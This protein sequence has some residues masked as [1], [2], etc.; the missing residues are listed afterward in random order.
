[1]NSLVILGRQPELGLAELESLYGAKNITSFGD[2]F[3]LVDIPA[4]KIDFDRLGSVIKLTT[5]LT[6]LDK[7]DWISVEKYLLKMV[8]EHL[9]YIPEEGKFNF[10]LSN[11]GLRASTTQITRTALTIKKVIKA[12]GRSVRIVPNKSAALS[13][14]QVL[15]NHLAGATRGWEV[16]SVRRGGKVIVCLTM[17]EQDIEAYTARDQ[18]RPKRDAFVGMLPPKLAQTIINLATGLLDKNKKDSSTPLPI[19]DTQ[20][21]TV[22]D[23]FCGTGVVLQE[24]LLMGYSAYGTDISPK[25][26]EYSTENI[27]WLRERWESAKEYCRIELGDATSFKWKQPINIVAGETYL[28]QPISMMPDREKLNR[29]IAETNELH[30]KTLQNLAS[31]LEKG[32]RLC[33]AVPT[34]RTQKGF[35]RL[36]ILDQIEKL[37]Y[38]LIDF[39]LVSAKRLIYA[40][41]DQIV[42]RELVTIVKK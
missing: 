17:R 23:P 42:G 37:G 41:E 8:I 4:D 9:D 21:P 2:K 13:T 11:Y 33:L 26:V 36:P 1:M 25:M 10:G 5:V 29:L 16:V 28:G 7:D 6:E 22:L 24:A 14:P 30:K 32:T 40:R 38:N 18:A 34:W 35:A 15:H 19:S 3:A 12:S 31:Q 27:L 20:V 39:E